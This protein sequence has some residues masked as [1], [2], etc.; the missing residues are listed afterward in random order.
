MI[1]THVRT[2]INL[3]S[4][5][6]LDQNR[7]RERL[8]MTG[9]LIKTWTGS[10]GIT[11]NWTKIDSGSS[12]KSGYA[13]GS[14]VTKHPRLHDDHGEDGGKGEG[15]RRASPS[16]SVYFSLNFELFSTRKGVY[17]KT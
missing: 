17:Y 6:K 1:G 9:S 5:R 13:T 15:G 2:G 4:D 14:A 11:K 16:L 7:M 12:E 3:N 10:V 8:T